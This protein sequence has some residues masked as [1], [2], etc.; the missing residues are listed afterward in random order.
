MTPRRDGAPEPTGADVNSSLTC[1]LVTSRLTPLER[2]RHLARFETG[3]G[4]VALDFRLDGLADEADRVEL[5]AKQV[6]VLADY[7]RHCVTHGIPRYERQVPVAAA[8]DWFG[9]FD[10][11]TRF[12]RAASGL[13][14]VPVVAHVDENLTTPHALRRQP[15]SAEHAGLVA[16]AHA[17]ARATAETAAGVDDV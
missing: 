4:A 7:E 2:A 14:N 11:H 16:L 6:G 15:A 17:S 12:L 10:A 8:A 9:R 3:L 5:V 13:G 1:P